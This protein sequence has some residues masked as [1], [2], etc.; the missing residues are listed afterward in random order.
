MEVAVGV[1]GGG[2]Y[3]HGTGDGGNSMLAPGDTMAM[4]EAAMGVLAT[5]DTTIVEGSGYGGY[6]CGR[7]L[8][9]N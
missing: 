9:M 8:L 5:G 4:A 1:H 2:C 3:H 7:Q 6:Y